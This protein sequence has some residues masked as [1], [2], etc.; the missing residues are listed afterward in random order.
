MVGAADDTRTVIGRAAMMP[1]QLMMASDHDGLLI[2]PSKV[3]EISIGCNYIS[4]L[5]LRV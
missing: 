4:L 3:I 1:L 5:S 2:G